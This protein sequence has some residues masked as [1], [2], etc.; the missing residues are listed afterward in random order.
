MKPAFALDF[1]DGAVAVLHRTAR[2]WIVVGQTSFDSP[3]MEEALAFLRSTALGLSPGGVA[4][5]LIIPN[6]QIKY[7]T[8]RAPGPDAAKR[9]R[10]IAT[11]LEGRTP[12]AVSDLVFDWWGKGD[13]VTVAVIA[14]E[15]LAEAEGFAHAHRFN[16]LSFVAVPDSGGFQAEPWFGLTSVADQILAAGEKVDRDQDPVRI[17]GRDAGPGADAETIKA[18]GPADGADPVPDPLPEH[19][20]QPAQ[21]L[22]PDPAAKP[23]PDPDPVSAPQPSPTPAPS[24]QPL[25]DLAIPADKIADIAPPLAITHPAPRTEPVSMDRRILPDTATPAPI[26][27]PEAMP[28]Q[29]SSW[30]PVSPKVDIAAPPPVAA[31]L[32]MAKPAV[33]EPTVPEPVV[34]EPATDIPV[35]A[36]VAPPPAPQEAPMAL[37]V[38]DSQPEELTDEQAGDLAKTANVS[39]SPAPM[40]GVAR[41]AAADKDTLANQGFSLLR[42]FTTRRKAPAAPVRAAPLHPEPLAAKPTPKAEPGLVAFTAAVRAAVPPPVAF[43]T[44]AGSVTDP[45]LGVD[46]TARADRPKVAPESSGMAVIGAARNPATLGKMTADRP[47]MARPLPVPMIAKGA[48]AKSAKGLKGFGAFVTAPNI[49]GLKKPRVATPPQAPGTPPSAN[50]SGVSPAR[51][52]TRPIG[53]GAKP[54]PQKGKPRFLG[55]VLTGILLVLLALVAAWSTFFLA[56]NTDAATTTAVAELTQPAASDVPAPE[57]EM[58]ADLQDPA[59]FTEAEATQDAAPAD[60]A[61]DLALTDDAAAAVAPDP[62]VLETAP[63][64]GLVSQTGAA[65]VS[66]AGDAQDEI[67]L[68]AIDSPPQPP[69]PSAL[70]APSARTDALPSPAVPPPPFGTVYQFDADGRIIPTPEGIATPEGVLLVAGRPAVVPTSRPDA[71]VAAALAAATPTAPA[72][73]S[74]AGNPSTV[75]S[76]P[77]AAAV[78]APAYADPALQGLRPQP[79]PASLQGPTQNG[80]AE[81]PTLAPTLAPESDS[82]FASLRPQPRPSAIAAP[83]VDDAAIEAA[84][85]SA[86]LMTQGQVL[87]Q[88]SN[89]LTV[90]VSRVPAARPKALETAA[91]SAAVAASAPVEQAAAAIAPEADAEPEQTGAMPGLPTTASVAKQATVKDAVNLSKLTLIGIYGSDGRRYALVRQPNGRLLKVKVGDKLDGG[92][93]AAITTSE[94]TYQK[95]G[96][97]VTLAMPRT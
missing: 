19:L 67:F 36:T 57:D 13:E 97:A 49:N 23:M 55:L 50:P 38:M 74:G 2:G 4:T 52:G 65:T 56:F 43:G 20:P 32:V 22:T 1:R 40:A 88:D 78:I 9:R 21:A 34:P 27:T 94:L 77:A 60:P 18:A 47:A 92:K 58:L 17:L 61:A 89:P 25:S 3:D 68:A 7:L 54:L 12:Y 72:P 39:L 75:L 35:L 84:V 53:L 16:P 66:P 28:Q 71:V 90:A 51:P 95:G 33:P 44:R 93:V 5:K 96:R 70:G 24:G 85:Q 63:D 73:E 76:D 59:D 15:T 26:W 8:I 31:D 82:R 42:A 46:M 37:D 62:V 64:T 86:S 41:T 14:R 30:Q 80:A 10:Q 79:R 48:P 6:D 81:D 69:D 45:G 87:P 29:P 11:A 83:A 91:S